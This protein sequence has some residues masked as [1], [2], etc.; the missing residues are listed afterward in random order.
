MYFLS[1]EV[2]AVQTFV[3]DCFLEGMGDLG[4]AEK[5]GGDHHNYNHNYNR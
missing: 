2:D 3:E 5:T 4:Y 1:L